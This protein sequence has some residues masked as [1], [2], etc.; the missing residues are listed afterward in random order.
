MTPRLALAIDLINGGRPDLAER[1]LRRHLAREPEDAG[2]HGLLGV[3]LAAQ[4]K[5]AEALAAAEEGARLEPG[6]PW[7]LQAFAEAHVRLGRGRRAEAAAREALAL[8]PL[9]PYFHALLARA[10]LVRSWLRP[11]SRALN[12]EALRA[13]EAGLALDPVNVECML[14]RAQALVRLG[15][16]EEARR[17]SE[18]ALRLSP[19]KAAP[20]AVH[21]VVELASGSRERGR[22]RLREALRLDPADPFARVRLELSGDPPLRDFAVLVLQAQDW[23]V[24]LGAVF[25]VLLATTCV[26]L[27]RPAPG[28]FPWLPLVPLG[29]VLLPLLILGP[30]Y[31]RHR[32]LLTDLREPG[33]LQPRER[34]WARARIVLWAVFG[35]GSAAMALFF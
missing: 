27:A 29:Y 14:Q 31:A 7:V 19:E 12:E 34:F 11:F 26:A 18:A 10:L 24:P 4:R 23:K 28:E 25:A 30:T 2:A 5:G 22:A 33:A 21:G 6:H 16:V 1:E 8:H 3:A 32:H 15:R 35:L 13:A 17:A 9:V 20:H